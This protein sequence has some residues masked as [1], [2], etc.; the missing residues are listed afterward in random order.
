[1]EYVVEVRQV[2]AGPVS[3]V[4][5]QATRGNLPKRIRELFDQFYAGFKSNGELN[6]IYYPGPCTDAG[7]EIGCGVQLES[8]GTAATPAGT[9]ATTVYMGPYDKMGPAHEAI[10]RWAR[11]NGRKLAGP[12]WEVY[13][14]WNDDPTKLRTDIFYLLS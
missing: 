1:M 14:H 11:E 12:S 7:F 9:V 8:G 6:I 4:R 2:A 3:M 10:C 5:G 13:G